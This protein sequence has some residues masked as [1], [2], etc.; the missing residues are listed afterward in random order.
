MFRFTA[1][2]ALAVWAAAAPAA[3]ILVYGDSLSAGYGLPPDKGWASLLAGRLGEEGFNYKV[4]NAS[5]S[6][7]T[8]LGGKKRIAASLQ[9]HQPAIVVLALGANDGLRG[10][11]LDEMRANLETMVDASRRSGARVLLVGMRLPP[12]YGAAYTEKFRK[13]FG[14]V[15]ASRKVPLVPFLFEGFAEKRDLFQPDTVHPAVAAQP[16]M[17]DTV[18]KGLRPLLKKS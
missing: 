6:G 18:W 14:E 16:L 3:T 4:A 9:Q 1:A 11:D 13:I 7:E 10:G 8:T 15:A 5:I 17:L 2:C 12:N